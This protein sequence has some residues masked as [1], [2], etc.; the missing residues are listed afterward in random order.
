MSK[1][2]LNSITVEQA[3]AAYEKGIA[4]TLDNGEVVAEIEAEDYCD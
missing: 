2:L 4:V 1:D 3:M